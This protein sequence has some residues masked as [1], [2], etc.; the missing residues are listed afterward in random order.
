MKLS[1]SSKLPALPSKCSS[2]SELVR[3]KTLYNKSVF[4]FECCR[5][6]VLTKRIKRL[7]NKNT[8]AHSKKNGVGLKLGSGKDEISAIDV[9]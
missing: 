6:E 4:A 9:D 8:T 2:R 1:Q 7:G 3:A 5:N